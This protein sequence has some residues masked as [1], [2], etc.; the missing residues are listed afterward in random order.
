MFYTSQQLVENLGDVSDRIFHL[1]PQKNSLPGHRLRWDL[2]V[3]DSLT[4]FKVCFKIKDRGLMAKA[5][6]ITEFIFVLVFLCLLLLLLFC[7]L[8]DLHISIY[9]QRKE[10]EHSATN[11]LGL[12]TVDNG[13]HQRWEKDVD[14]A[15]KDM[16]DGG[17]M[18][19]KT[20]DHC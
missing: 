3:S 16:D 17:E 19:A 8:K 4:T 5:L 10:F 15:H 12:H 11:L 1:Q 18:L 2:F 7:F 14:V 13:V 6:I 20:V 9:F